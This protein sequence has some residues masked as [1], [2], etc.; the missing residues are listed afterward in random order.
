MP[1]TS[2]CDEVQM[3]ISSSIRGRSAPLALLLSGLALLVAVVGLLRVSESPPASDDGGT[4]RRDSA[5]VAPAVLQ[6]LAD[7][8]QRIAQLETNAGRMPVIDQSHIAA[9]VEEALAARGTAGR[10]SPAGTDA[11]VA[12]RKASAIQGLLQ[13]LTSTGYGPHRE[14]LWQQLRKLGGTDEAVKTFERLAAE[15]PN[16]PDAQTAL[17]AAYIEKMLQSTDEAQRIALGE[18]IEAQFDRALEL[19]PDHWEARFRKAVGLSYGPPLSGRQQQ[20]VRQFEQLVQ[21]QGSLPPQAGFAETY[22]YLGRLY[23][24]QGS[25][26]R[27]AAVWQQGLSRHPQDTA[28]QQLA[29]SR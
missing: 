8:R 17:G 1:W 20:A 12:A 22:V 27:A 18:K 15:N 19:Q 28:L 13:E 6:E 3:T 29:R 21:Q 26:D 23:E 7:L 10:T 24:Q 4:P 25:L 16:S 11:A 9:L 5:T 14:E 2:P